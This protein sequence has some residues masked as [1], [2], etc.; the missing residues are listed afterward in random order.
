MDYKAAFGMRGLDLVNAIKEGRFP[1]PPV[2]DLVNFRLREVAE[3]RVVFEINPAEYHYNCFGMVQ[4]GI[5]CAVLDAGAGYALHSTLPAGTGYTTLE[6]KVNYLRP[7]SL[8][9]GT[10]RCLGT[11]IHKG[12]RVAVAQADM[13]DS[14]NLLYAHAISTCLVFKLTEGV[15]REN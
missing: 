8:E 1:L 3:G 15:R 5:E 13:L 10:I 6:L 9:T 14:N 2:W 11:V 7:I 4:G 12:S